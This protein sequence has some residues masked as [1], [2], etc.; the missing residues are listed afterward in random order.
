MT[1]NAESNDFESGTPCLVRSS[2]EVTLIDD[3]VICA[4]VLP[5]QYQYFT[6]F[7]QNSYVML[8][9]ETTFEINNKGWSIE[10]SEDGQTWKKI[11]IVSAQGQYSSYS[12]KDE[13]IPKVEV[14][15]YRLKQ[16][17]WDGKYSYTA[18]RKITNSFE[19][20]K[21]EIYPNP[22]TGTFYLKVA[23]EDLKIQVFDQSGRE[24]HVEQLS[25]NMYHIARKGIFILRIHTPLGLQHQR[26]IIQ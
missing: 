20:N 2:K 22:T 17:D 24:I 21:T 5:V 3:E 9:W 11:G 14:L 1:A 26:L 15:Y 4:G 23:D 13:N 19:A 16:E 25:S 12:Y 8:E 18:V 7:K 10:R 6:V